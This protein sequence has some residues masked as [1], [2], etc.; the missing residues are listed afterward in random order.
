MTNHLF[1]F[2]HMILWKVLLPKLS[3][4]LILF[5]NRKFQISFCLCFSL[6]KKTTCT[7]TKSFFV[8]L[9]LLCS[10]FTLDS[11]KWF[12][13]LDGSINMADRSKLKKMYHLNLTKLY[14]DFFVLLLLLLWDL[15]FFVL[16]FL[17]SILGHQRLSRESGVKG[18]CLCEVE[19]MKGGGAVKPLDKQQQKT[20]GEGQFSS[21]VA[22]VS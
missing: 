14:V 6:Y 17:F 12:N 16:F 20:P 10:C 13:L 19:N 21:N 15:G 2:C 3:F 18:E 1:R 9:L 5:F 4:F 8:L 22:S 11:R 7:G